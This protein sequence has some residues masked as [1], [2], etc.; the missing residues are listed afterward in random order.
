[1]KAPLTDVDIGG[2]GIKG[3]LVNPAKPKF[4][5]K[6]LYCPTPR[7]ATP[8]DVTQI[9]AR[10]VSDLSPTAEGH[11]TATHVTSHFPG[12]ATVGEGTRLTL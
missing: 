4:L 3:A 8:T 9:V 11:H 10:L 7:P 5:G 2:T 1:M 6:A 12:S